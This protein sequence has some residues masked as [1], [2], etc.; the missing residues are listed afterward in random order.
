[1]VEERRER[2]R[3]RGREGGREGDLKASTKVKDGEVYTSGSEEDIECV[4]GHERDED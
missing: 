2:G 3:K 1:M 4:D